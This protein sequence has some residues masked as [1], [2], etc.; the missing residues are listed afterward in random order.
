[1]NQINNYLQAH[2]PFEVGSE[3]R[4]SYFSTLDYIGRPV[5]IIKKANVISSLHDKYFQVYYNIT[6]Y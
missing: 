3:E 4:G 2:L 1:M 6:N 5:V